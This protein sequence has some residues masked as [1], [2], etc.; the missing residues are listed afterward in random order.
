MLNKKHHCLAFMVMFISVV[1][2]L[3]KGLKFS[4]WFL[5]PKLALLRYSV[6]FM[7]PIFMV[8]IYQKVMC[9]SVIH[10]KGMFLYFIYI[11]LFT[12]LLRNLFYESGM[13]YG[14][15]RNVFVAFVF[16]SYFILHYL[17][18]PEGL[19]IKSL[20]VIGLM[21]L[22]IQIYQNL[23]PE[24]ALFSM[25]TEEMRQEMGL[26]ADY[27]TGMRNGIYRFLPISQHFPLFL[28]CYYLSKFF[29]KY[30][31]VYLLLTCAFAASIYLTLTRMFMI[32][33]GICFVFMYLS[34]DKGK[35]SNVSKILTIILICILMFFYW[36][37]LFSDLFS[38]T[39]SDIDYSSKVRM[40]CYPFLL[41]QSVSN[42]LLFIIGHGYPDILWQWGG[43]LGYWYN[44]I[45]VF[46]Q[47]FPYGI[48]W[49]VVYIR[50]VYW[51][52]I[53]QRKRIPVYIR[54]YIFGLFCICMVMTT[55]ATLDTVLLFCILMYISD[56]YINRENNIENNVI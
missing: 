35:M 8:S 18:V 27:V 37:V 38:S 51:V 17:M 48:I 19:L 36:G 53:K 41:G 23:H 13:G 3:T 10:N 29:T 25:Y 55:Y 20:T 54:S 11:C 6:L 44:D 46:G 34:I 4:G 24:Q 7:S 12:F 43:K 33:G 16:C 2:L 49:F 14:L 1:L 5:M 9:R 52:L 47:I 56:L 21:V 26:S 30:K 42:P 28:F 32:C 22:L 45:G 39:E 15:E 50:M 40:E 31:F